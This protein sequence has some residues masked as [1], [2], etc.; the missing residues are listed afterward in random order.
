MSYATLT[1]RSI[2]LL[3]DIAHSKTPTLA[4]EFIRLCPTIA[5][6]DTASEAADAVDS[7]RPSNRIPGLS[8][9]QIRLEFTQSYDIRILAECAPF[10]TLNP[11]CGLLDMTLPALLR[12]LCLSY[13][14]HVQR[15]YSH[16]FRHFLDA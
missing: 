9:R 1:T 6:L 13:G 4:Y 16:H 5:H 10:L 14:A 2:A 11:I 3:G 15:Y 8:L 12:T 7:T